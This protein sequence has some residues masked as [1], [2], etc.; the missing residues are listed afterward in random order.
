MRRSWATAEVIR[1]HRRKTARAAKMSG[2]A[3]MAACGQWPLQGLR[4]LGRRNEER[5]P[6]VGQ[7]RLCR[8]PARDG[9]RA[10]DGEPEL[11]YVFA[12]GPR[13]G[14]CDSK[15]AARPSAWA[16]QELDALSYPAI[17]SPE[18]APSIR[19]AESLA[20]SGSLMRLQ[21]RDDR[22]FRRRSGT[23][24]STKRR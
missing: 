23:A 14:N 6:I 1:H 17:I 10:I 18:N 7:L 3:A 21:R 19:L 24:A 4:L 13:S 2:A 22:L 12:G 11:G 8:F 9:R 5:W 15:R 16:D 20:S